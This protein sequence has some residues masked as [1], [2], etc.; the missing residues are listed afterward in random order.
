MYSTGLAY[1][2][3]RTEEKNKDS[4]VQQGLIRIP[5]KNGTKSKKEA[6]NE[7]RNNYDAQV[8]YRRDFYSTKH[9]N[10]KMTCAAHS[11]KQMNRMC[12]YVTEHWKKNTHS[13]KG[14]KHVTWTNLI[15]KFTLSECKR[16]AR[17]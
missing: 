4:N 5:R 9:K 2:V 16:N 15:S 8:I 6:I 17:R 13:I 3:K 11:A 7:H 12:T 14:G 10:P 1:A